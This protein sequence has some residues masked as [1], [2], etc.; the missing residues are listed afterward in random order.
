MRKLEPES[1]LESKEVKSAEDFFKERH[2]TEHW[3]KHDKKIHR[4]DYYDMVDF[5]SQYASQFKHTNEWVSVKEP[6]FKALAKEKLDLI[7]TNW[8]LGE[9]AQIYALVALEQAFRQGFRLGK[10][11][12]NRS[13]L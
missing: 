8:K 10:E 7:L 5:A 3:D 1:P 13:K 6:D 2:A 11:Q 4:Y 12:A 9:Q